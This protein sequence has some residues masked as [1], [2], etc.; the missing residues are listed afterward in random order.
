VLF[1]ADGSQVES[2]LCFVFTGDERLIKLA[3]LPSWEFDAHKYVASILP[4]K[5]GTYFG[6]PMLDIPG[7]CPERQVAKSIGHAAQRAVQAAT[8]MD[9]LLKQDERFA[10]SEE[11]VAAMLEAYY[12]AFPAIRTWHAQIRREIRTKKCLTSTWGHVW[13]VR[14]EEINDDLFR[15][16][17]SWRLQRDC[18]G[19]TNQMGFIP[20]WRWLKARGMSSR[21]MLQEHDSLVCSCP[22][23]EVYDVARYLRD[24]MEQPRCYDGVELSVPVE[25]KLG[26]SWG[27][28]YEYAQLPDRETFEA[29]AREFL[30]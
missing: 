9:T 7:K 6:L 26:R 17:Y 5:N 18:A 21:I 29:K 24:A 11:E 14:Y 10:Y 19:L 2:R 8:A 16:A 22:L 28:T 3:R 15:R 30:A 4:K 1:E 25:M 27:E 13:D 12:Q 23:E 20:L